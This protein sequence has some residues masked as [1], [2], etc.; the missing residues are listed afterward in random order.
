MASR[1][2]QTALTLTF[3][4]IIVVIGLYLYKPQ[5]QDPYQTELKYYKNQKDHTIDQTYTWTEFKELDGTFTQVNAE[6]L[7][8]KAKENIAEL[9]HC[10]IFID[11]NQKTIWISGIGPDPTERYVYYCPF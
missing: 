1:N 3:I 2:K 7:R 6:I 9:E 4:I 8:R 11:E 10:R 5:K